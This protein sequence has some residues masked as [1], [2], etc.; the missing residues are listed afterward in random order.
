MNEVSNATVDP[1]RPP[2]LRRGDSV[3]IC[4]PASPVE[5][6]RLRRGVQ[7]LSRRYRVHVSEG[8][9]AADGYLAGDDDRRADEFNQL[10]ADP[11]VRAIFPAAGGYGITRILDRLDA[12]LLRN[13]PKIIVGFSEATAL[14]CWA[15]TAAGVRGIHGPMAADLAERS[16]AQQAHLMDMLEGK[17][18]RRVIRCQREPG[19][20]EQHPGTTDQAPASAMQGRLMGGNL[21]LLSVLIGTPY[22]IALLDALMF[23]ED[24]GKPPSV[25]DRLLTHMQVA[26][27][28][29]GARAALLGEL[30][31]CE[32]EGQPGPSARA[33][34]IE[35]MQTFGI[36]MLSGLPAG[37]G[38]DNLALPFGAA[39][40]I[41]F[42]K[43]ELT[44]LEPAVDG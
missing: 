22:Q 19:D 32:D 4:A 15:Y 20:S 6:D 26:G 43:R 12:G 8:V 37:H 9:L 29:E 28:L 31:D 30:S 27:A 23:I 35:R 5:R 10:L 25:I 21:T 11:D 24:I 44:L 16:P 2:A 42:N 13:D 1:I 41:D 3:A 40:A 38:A 14:L 17:E 18:Q 33:V 39:A 34:V 36:P 7:V